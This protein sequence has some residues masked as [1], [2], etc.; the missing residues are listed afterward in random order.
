MSAGDAAALL[1]S[2]VRDGLLDGDAVNAVLRAAGHRAPVRRDAPAGL[3]SRELEVLALL[4]RGQPNKQIARELG[5][6]VKTVSNHVEHVYAKI[7]VRSRAAATLFAT[8]HGLVGAFE[9]STT[10][11]EGRRS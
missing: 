1:R 9:P 7:G 10:R 5:V 4:A 3:T 2:E 11:D 6:A 8:Q